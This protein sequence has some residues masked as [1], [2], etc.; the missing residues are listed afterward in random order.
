MKVET[1]AERECLCSLSS[2][3]CCHNHSSSMLSVCVYNQGGFLTCFSLYTFSSPKT[4]F[5]LCNTSVFAVQSGSIAVSV[6]LFSTLYKSRRHLRWPCF[7]EGWGFHF[8]TT[9]KVHPNSG[10]HPSLDAASLSF[11]ELGLP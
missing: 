11:S 9:D 3:F 7:V 10:K 2:C 6:S 4:P 1:M 5:L 8:H